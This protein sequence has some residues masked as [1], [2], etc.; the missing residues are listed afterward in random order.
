MSPRWR[1]PAGDE[2]RRAGRYEASSD[3]KRPF[4]PLQFAKHLHLKWNLLAKGPSNVLVHARKCAWT[5]PFGTGAGTAPSLTP[6]VPPA[7]QTTADGR[8]GATMPS[9]PSSPSRGFCTR[10]PA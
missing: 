4:R 1:H 10:G 6:H 5:D 2:D 7:V 3:G 9:L 8:R